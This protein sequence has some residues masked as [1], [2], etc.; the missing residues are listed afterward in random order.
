MISVKRSQQL[1]QI[2]KIRRL[3]F[4]G[5]RKGG[6][7]KSLC[8]LV[9]IEYCLQYIRSFTLA[10]CDRVN[11]D[12]ARI[13]RKLVKVLFAYFSEDPR[14]R[15]KADALFK[16]VL[17]HSLVICNL[18]AQVH[19]PMKAWFLEDG[20]CELAQEHNVVSYH[21]YISN[22]GYDS[23]KLFIK[24]LEDLGPY[25]QHV[26]VRNW[27]LCDDWTHVDE[28]EDVQAAIQAYQV[29]VIDLPK[30]PYVERNFIESHQ[31]TLSEA[32]THADLSLISKQRIKQFLRYSF[33][34]IDS[35]G[36]MPSETEET[37]HLKN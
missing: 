4:V 36:L 19:E 25:I 35:T 3:I 2:K 31:I 1:R 18:P 22:G 26:F 7:G 14:K 12:A 20:L 21:W 23:V 9:L 30:F 8:T 17:D 13:Y 24:T 6:V 10:E 33:A 5:G 28:D 27:G 16:A 34:E 15:T 37:S 11:P 29:P 32:L